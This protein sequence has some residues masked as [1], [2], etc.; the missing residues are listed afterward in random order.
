MTCYLAIDL[1]ERMKLDLNTFSVTV[2]K[3]ACSM[4]GTTAR[5]REGDV[6]K[7]IDLLHAL[8]LPSGNDAAVAIAEG[9]GKVLKLENEKK[10]A[11]AGAK[12][13]TEDRPLKS[14]FAYFIEAMNQKAAEL[15]L[16]D[17][18]YSNPH[19][20]SHS[21]NLS[22]A[23]DVARLC[24][25]AM[26]NEIF[27]KIVRKKEYTCT[28]FQGNRLRREMTWENTNKLLGHGYEGV[29]TGITPTAGPCL[30][31]SLRRSKDRH[32]ICVLLNASDLD[33]RF[34]ESR[35]LM[36]YGERKMFHKAFDDIDP[37]K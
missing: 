9:L 31:S 11:Q 6:L 20:L 26:K 2:S 13:N 32:L 19:G 27:R 8:M 24:I 14:S 37:Y 1:A 16:I 30:A 33:T 34:S 23:Y 21:N 35:R 17:T 15:E 28:V 22:S 7:L 3:I 12:E 36:E 5:L 4:F 25:T 29:K 10:L 18:H